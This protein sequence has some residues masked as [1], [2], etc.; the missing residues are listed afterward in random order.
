ME[1]NDNNKSK[2]GLGK[3]LVWTFVSLASIVGCYFTVATVALAVKPEMRAILIPFIP[4][5]TQEIVFVTVQVPITQRPQPTALFSPPLEVTREVTREV[6]VV[7][8]ATLPQATI[9]P[10]STVT[11][12]PN[13]LFEDDFDT[14]LDPAWQILSGNPLVVN[15]SLTTDQQTWIIVGDSSWMNYT[16]KFDAD[17]SSCW[18][19]GK[20]NV[21][22]VRFVNLDNMIA[23]K[24]VDC[25]SA[26]YIV[27]NGIWNEV[28]NSRFGPG[29]G[30]LRITI[31]VEGDQ[32]IIYV[33]DQKQTSFIS[34]K[35]P[36]GRVGLRLDP[37]TLIDNFNIT[38]IDR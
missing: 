21:I 13:L 34:G 35:F 31:N 12:P 5:P 24:W 10:L 27:E 7:V 22:A 14:G 11:S 9:T 18:F 29:Y 38:A 25:E 6:T 17:A 4:E 20:G 26:W 33:G 37:N 2:T 1:S 16:I 8:T 36:N 23:F 30:L 3:F 28:P 32:F 19:Y 15:D